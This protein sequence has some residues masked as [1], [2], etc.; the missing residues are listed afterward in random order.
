MP[1]ETYDKDGVFS[2]S[3]I[4]WKDKMYLFY[5]GNVEEEGDHDYIHSGRGAECDPRDI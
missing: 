2:G 1:D 4:V 5:T 3:A